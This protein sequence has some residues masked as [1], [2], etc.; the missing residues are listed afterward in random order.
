MLDFHTLSIVAHTLSATG[1]FVV[2]VVLIFQRDRLRQLQL[3]IAFLALLLLLEVFLAIAILSHVTSLLTMTQIIFGGLALLG[4][5][6]IWRAAQA[7]SVLREPHGNQGAVVDHVGFDLISLFD[8]FAIISAI[9]LQAPG[10]LVAAIAVGAVAVGIY[11][12]N[13]RKRT[14]PRQSM[15]TATRRNR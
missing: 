11:A 1:A 5:Y 7:V 14:L 15:S 13:S 3:G 8:G 10:W 9:D 4:L 12:I 2:G 6:M